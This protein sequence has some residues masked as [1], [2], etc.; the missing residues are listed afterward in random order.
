MNRQNVKPEPTRRRR[1]NSPI[2]QAVINNPEDLALIKQA[3]AINGA[4]VS[5]FVRTAAVKAARQVVAAESV[6]AS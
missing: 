1:N 5:G 6:T 2:I 3:A 4:A